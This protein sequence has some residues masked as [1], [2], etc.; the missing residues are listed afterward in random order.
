MHLDAGGFTGFYREDGLLRSSTILEAYEIMG[1]AAVN[2]CYKELADRFDHIEDLKSGASVPMLSANIVYED[3]K[4]AV[5]DPSIKVQAGS[6]TVGIVGISDMLPRTW[7]TKGGRTVVM[8]D[9]IPAAKQHIE[10]L[11]DET[12]LIILLAHVQYRRLPEL[13]ALADV[14]LIIGADG[15]TATYRLADSGGPPA[16]FGGRQ[17][18]NIGIVSI[19]MDD[20]GK[21]DRFELEMVNLRVKMP[22]DDE[23]KALVDA[24][25]RKLEAAA[26][27]AEAERL[28]QVNPEYAGYNS[29]R[30]CHR[31]AYSAWTQTAHYDAFNPIITNKKATD[32]ECLKCHTTGFGDG[33]FVDIRLTP[34]MVHVQ[35]EACHGPGRKHAS[36]PEGAGGSMAADSN[37][38]Q[39]C[40]DKANSPKFDYEFYWGKIKH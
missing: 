18:K 14:D 35:C 6:Y 3:N 26:V 5:F 20:K 24:A 37:V 2:V 16:A 30:S 11:A 13:A 38:C 31:D 12:D 25:K 9:P 22:E 8:T 40:H 27:A 23:M 39:R 32:S 4:E 33:G 15:Y 34:R 1:V 29:C 21:P 36:A 17:G 10:K 28:E 19:W 7:K